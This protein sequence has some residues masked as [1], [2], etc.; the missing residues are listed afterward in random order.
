MEVSSGCWGKESG[1]DPEA[2]VAVAR[3]DFAGG[4]IE[5]VLREPET[6]ARCLDEQSRRRLAED[7]VDEDRSP[8]WTAGHARPLCSAHHRETLIVASLWPRR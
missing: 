8:T 6:L 1:V 5:A 4:E 3:G 2:D 7:F